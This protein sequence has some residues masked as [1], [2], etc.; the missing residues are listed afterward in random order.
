MDAK[1]YGANWTT[2]ELIERLKEV[3]EIYAEA[4]ARADMGLMLPPA[5]REEAAFDLRRATLLRDRVVAVHRARQEAAHK[6]YLKG[7]GML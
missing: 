5:E 6:E 3:G 7:R 1:T 4:K 2:E